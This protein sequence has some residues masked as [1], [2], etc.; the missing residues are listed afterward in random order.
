[1]A[2]DIRDSDTPVSANVHV[3]ASETLSLSSEFV[4]ENYPWELSDSTKEFIQQKKAENMILA[5]KYGQAQTSASQT[6]PKK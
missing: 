4:E 1:M 5:E 3:I 6:N 2:P